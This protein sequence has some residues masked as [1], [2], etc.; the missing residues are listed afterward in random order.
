MKKIFS[1]I[2]D[3]I[4]FLATLFLL[5]F[6]PLYPKLP[7]IDIKNTWVYVRIEDFIVLFVLLAWLALFIRKKISLKTP[8]TLPIIFFWII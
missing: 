4:L 7:L 8:L 2:S 5:F 3:N 1:W 6:I